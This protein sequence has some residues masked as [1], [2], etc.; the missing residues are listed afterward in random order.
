[1]HIERNSRLGGISERTIGEN[2]SLHWKIPC[3][4]AARSFNRPSQFARRIEVLGSMKQ[5]AQKKPP[6]LRYL[7]AGPNR[8]WGAL[9]LPKLTGSAQVLGM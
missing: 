8:P 1:M 9:P 5:K 3:G 4:F 6:G 7:A 2:N